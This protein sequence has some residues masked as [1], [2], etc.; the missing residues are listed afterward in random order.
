MEIC[1]GIKIKAEK[2]GYNALFAVNSQFIVGVGVIPDRT[3]YAAFEPMLEK[4]MNEPL[5]AGRLLILC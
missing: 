3:D 2:P 1:G 4:L 5:C